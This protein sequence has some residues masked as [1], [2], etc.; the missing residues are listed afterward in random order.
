MIQFLRGTRSQLNSYSTIIPAG[1]PVFESDTGQLKIGTGNSRY[2]ALEYVG[3]IFESI[4]SGGGEVT[5]GGSGYNSYVDF[6]GGL[7]LSYGVMDQDE[8]YYT[9]TNVGGLY[10]RGGG[11]N[12]VF[13]VYVSSPKSNI[14]A[15][16]LFASLADPYSS[17]NRSRDI[18][19]T[20][21]WIDGDD[22]SYRIAWRGGSSSPAC[23]LTF[24]AWSRD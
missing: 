8:G 12:S 24:T 18:F 16:S 11:F 10:F 13:G 14:I 20:S 15:H 6:P 3:S 7:R 9:G 5:F 21:S 1:Q 17:E 22:I 23:N 19:I 4:S 2:S